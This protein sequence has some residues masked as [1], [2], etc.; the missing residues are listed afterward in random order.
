ME[1][2]VLT[3]QQ[4]LNLIKETRESQREANEMYEKLSQETDRKFQEI[5]NR[6]KT[7]EKLVDKVS[8]DIGHLGNKFG[9]FNEA[10]VI[11]SLEKLFRE[12][13]HCKKIA[14]NFK[15]FMNGD[16]FEIDMFAISDVAVYVVEIKSNFSGDDLKQLTKQVQKVR[17]YDKD[18]PNRAIYGVIVASEYDK[19]HI[20][21]LYQKGIYFISISDDLVKFELP[22]NFVPKEW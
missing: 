10:I 8:R 9:R 22:E 6:F 11:P 15:F 20:D 5:A 3:Y 13:F 1:Q 17:K 12:K 18:F 2:E 21:K 4:V 14:P 19:E 7:T 16:S